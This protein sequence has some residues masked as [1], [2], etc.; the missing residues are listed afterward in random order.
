[1]L[2]GILRLAGHLGRPI[3]A[4]ARVADIGGRHLFL[5]M[6]TAC[7]KARTTTRFVTPSSPAGLPAWLPRQG[8]ATACVRR[9][10]GRSVPLHRKDRGDEG[11]LPVVTASR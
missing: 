8:C 10:R 7:C 9:R 5:L 1:M 4:T 6:S 2:A 11:R 3:N